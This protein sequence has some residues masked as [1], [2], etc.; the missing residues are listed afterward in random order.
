MIDLQNRR[1]VQPSQCGVQP[2]I[3]M[4]DRRGENNQCTPRFVCP[5]NEGIDYN[6][7]Q[8]TVEVAEVFKGNYQVTNYLS[9][10]ISSADI[11]T[12][13]KIPLYKSDQRHSWPG[14]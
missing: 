13:I 9:D 1:C 10:G 2:S 7:C 11:L 8:Y 6:F 14:F 5:F 12:D 3:T 4:V